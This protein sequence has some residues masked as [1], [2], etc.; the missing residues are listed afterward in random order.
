VN[1]PDDW[2]RK[3]SASVARMALQD[4]RSLTVVPVVPR[5]LNESIGQ[6]FL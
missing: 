1:N 4:N 3:L 5:V 6:F 2:T